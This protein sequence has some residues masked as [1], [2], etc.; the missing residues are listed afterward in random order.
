MTLADLNCAHDVLEGLIRDE[1]FLLLIS[2]IIDSL[3][4]IIIDILSKQGI[5]YVVSHLKILI[6]DWGLLFQVIIPFSCRFVGQ[7][8]IHKGVGIVED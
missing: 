8:L 4:V 6:I 1:C 2:L 7:G 5:V 3:G